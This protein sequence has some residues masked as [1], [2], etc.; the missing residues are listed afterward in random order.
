MFK[1][2]EVLGLGAQA[3]LRD[4]VAALEKIYTG[5]IGFEYMYIRDPQVLDWF[6]ARR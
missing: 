3:T 2:G 4:I 1:N 6:R 5:A